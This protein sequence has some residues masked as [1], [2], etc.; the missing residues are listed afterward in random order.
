[1]GRRRVLSAANSVADRW[2]FLVVGH[3]LA[4]WLSEVATQHWP[5]QWHAAIMAFV[6]GDD[7]SALAELPRPNLANFAFHGDF[8]WS[9]NTTLTR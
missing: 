3:G 4:C 6:Q 7:V 5:S 2:L 8:K 9:S 1:V